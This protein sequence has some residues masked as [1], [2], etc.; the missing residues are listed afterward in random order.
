MSAALVCPWQHRDCEAVG[1]RDARGRLLG[2]RDGA[3]PCHGAALPHQKEGPSGCLKDGHQ[4]DPLIPSLSPRL[5]PPH[6]HRL[7]DPRERREDLE[8][9][10]V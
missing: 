10:V 9:H 4:A 6:P 8:Q 7:Q 3:V 5:L 1:E 2:Q